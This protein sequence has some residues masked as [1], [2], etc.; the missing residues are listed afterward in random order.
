MRRGVPALDPK[1]DAELV[2]TAQGMFKDLKTY[3]LENGLRVYLLPDQG[4]A[5]RHDDGRV[6]RRGRR[7]RRRTRPGCRTTSNT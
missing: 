4:R 3:T 2:K 7:T 6:S 5:D 1:A